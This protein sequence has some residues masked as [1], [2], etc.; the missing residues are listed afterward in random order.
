PVN[1]HRDMFLDAAGKVIEGLSTRSA[2]ASG[3]PGSVDG[4]LRL[5]EDHGSGR[6]SRR[7]LLAP[8]IRLA[9]RGFPISRRLAASL[10]AARDDFAADPG[11]T[12]IF[13]RDDGRPWQP[14]DILK[15]R[16]L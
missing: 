7:E 11:A 14:G 6:I 12:E 16:D 9:R 4:L 15:Q 8:A 13:I 2:L 10:N 5:W 3:T 1:A